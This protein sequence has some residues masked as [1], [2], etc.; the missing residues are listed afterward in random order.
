MLTDFIQTN[1]ISL[2]GLEYVKNQ[3]MLSTQNL[4]KENISGN[5]NILYLKNLCNTIQT[6]LPKMSNP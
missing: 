4:K 1:K 3:G 6:L 5:S 2:S